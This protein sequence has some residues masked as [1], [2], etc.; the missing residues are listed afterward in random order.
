MVVRSIGLLTLLVLSACQPVTQQETF[1]IVL[2]APFEGRYREVGYDAL[3][4]ARLAL[5]DSGTAQ[6]TLL[7]VDDGGSAA[8]AVWRARGLAEDPRSI[9]AIVLGPHAAAPETLAALADIPTLVVGQWTQHPPQDYVFILSN[10]AIPELLTLPP[11]TDLT[12]AAGFTSPLT[13]S[14]PFALK[15]LPNLRRDLENITIISSAALP[16]DGFR[17][18]YQN[19]DPFAPEPGLLASLTYDAMI[20]LT[21]TAHQGRME[22]LEAIHKHQHIGLNGPIRF[23]DHYWANAPLYRYTYDTEGRLSTLEQ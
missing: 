5:Q 20:F 13:G 7:P 2:L 1:H 17:T 23:S 14:D 3:Y 11:D 22:T 4:A 19:A 8:N 15:Q 18:R 6:L 21:Q 10:P 16:D 9:A 12:V